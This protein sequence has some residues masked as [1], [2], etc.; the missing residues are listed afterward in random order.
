MAAT[1]SRWRIVFASV[2]VAYGVLAALGLAFVY[3]G[4]YDVGAD[5][6]HGSLVWRLL[7]TARQRSIKAHAE[8]LK[9]PEGFDSEAMIVIGVEHFAAHCAIC[10]GAPGVPR[11]DLAIGLYPAPPDLAQTA[12][13]YGDGELFW[14]VRHGIKMTG[15]P[16]WTDH[17]DDEIWAIVGFIRKLPGMDP[18]AYVKLVR[19]AMQRGGHHGHQHAPQPDAGGPDRR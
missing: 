9:P 5:T 2:V 4:L 10:H 3:S 6:P 14:I 15:M 17:S 7:E 8:G 19:A 12:A 11:G 18:D 16:G 13:R 1:G